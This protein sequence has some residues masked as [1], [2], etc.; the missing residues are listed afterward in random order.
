MIGIRRDAKPELQDVFA[1]SFPAYA[2]E[3]RLCSPTNS[4][5]YRMIRADFDEVFKDDPWRL[6]LLRNIDDVLEPLRHHGIVVPVFLIGGGFVRRLRDGSRPSDI[7]GLAFYRMERPSPEAVKALGTAIFTAKKLHI[8]MRLCPLDA[9][10][11]VT[12]KT[13]IFYSVLFSKVEGGMTIENGLILYDREPQATP[14]MT[15]I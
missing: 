9:D 6:R 15:I 11:I 3:E 8:D 2:Q 14:N 5:P 4:S 13:A 7:D 1:K 12:M 10:P